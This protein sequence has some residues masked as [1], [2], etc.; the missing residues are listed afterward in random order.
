MNRYEAAQELLFGTGLTKH[1]LGEFL[2]VTVKD[3][4]NL[5]WFRCIEKRGPDYNWIIRHYNL[6]RLLPILRAVSYLDQQSID[7]LE[8]CWT[9][10]ALT[11]RT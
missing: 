7:A 4:W 8:D 11:G 6:D 9:E 2:G 10:A 5:E 1:E 3:V